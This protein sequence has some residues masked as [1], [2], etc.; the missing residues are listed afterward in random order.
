MRNIHEFWA[1]L[2]CAALFG[3]AAA[4]WSALSDAQKQAYSQMYVN[5]N[6]DPALDDLPEPVGGAAPPAVVKSEAAPPAATKSGDAPKS[7]E[8][9]SLHIP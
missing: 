3:Q 6:E 8:K 7:P 4:A 2:P 1:L 5:N 9:A